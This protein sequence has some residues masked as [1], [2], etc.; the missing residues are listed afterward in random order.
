MKIEFNVRDDF[1]KDGRPLY[2]KELMKSDLSAFAKF[3]LAT[4][5]ETIYDVKIDGE[6][7]QLY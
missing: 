6:D 5:D 7:V 3:I 2:G 4:T 1:A